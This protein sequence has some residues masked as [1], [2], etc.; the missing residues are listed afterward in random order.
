MFQILRG[1]GLCKDDISDTGRECI[2]YGQLYTEYLNTIPKITLKT[3]NEIH[4]AIESKKGDI[5]LPGSGES[6]Y[7]ISNSA[8]VPSSG[9][10]YGGDLIILRPKIEIDSLY[11]S[12]YITNKLRREIY[13]IS[14]GVSII[15]LPIDDLSKIYL[16]YHSL[17]KQ[18]E[19]SRFIWLIDTKMDLL[20][21]KISTLKKYKKGIKNKS[22]KY[23]TLHGEKIEFL[24]LFCEYKKTNKNN[25]CQYTV[26]KNGLIKI[27]DINYDLSKHSIFYENCLLIGI[28]IDEVAVSLNNKGSVSPVY[29]VYSINDSYYNFYFYWFIKDLLIMQKRFLTKKS[30]RREFE[31]DKKELKKCKIPYVLDAFIK[32]SILTINSMDSKIK[33]YEERLINLGLVKVKILKDMFI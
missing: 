31:I 20:K 6:K 11:F 29:S 27:D 5:I 17:E 18:K 26:G 33:H 30:T 16:R 3:K 25:L 12:Y 13:K 22:L 4:N 32:F 9:V 24:K 10:I 7:D 8:V 19:I 28:G 2:L 23:I 21:H 15:H 14:Q 1:K